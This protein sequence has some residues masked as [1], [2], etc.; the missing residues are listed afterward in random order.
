M[1]KILKAMA[2]VLCAALLMAA[3]GLGSALLLKRR[4]TIA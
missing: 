2:L 1:K 4:K 3:S